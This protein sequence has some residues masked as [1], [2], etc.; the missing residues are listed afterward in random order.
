MVRY[1]IITTFNPRSQEEVGKRMWYCGYMIS[2]QCDKSSI[3]H[4]RV[5]N[6]EVFYV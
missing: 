1:L 4:I 2:L 5:V 6:M 3:C